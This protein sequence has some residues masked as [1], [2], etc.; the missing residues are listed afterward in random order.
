MRTCEPAANHFVSKARQADLFADEP[1][2]NDGIGRAE[3]NEVRLRLQKML[4]EA[5]A[6][7]SISP[8]NERTTR[9]NQTIFPQM[10]NWLPPAEA[11]QLR[12]EFRFELKRLGL[13]C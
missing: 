8:W 1:P 9:I 4:A 7:A 13:E 10:A 12:N 2:R 5:K 3:P 6:A 11:E